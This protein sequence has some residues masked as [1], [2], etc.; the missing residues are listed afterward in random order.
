VRC[1][2]AMP[3]PVPKMVSVAVWR[4]LCRKTDVASAAHHLGDG[5]QVSA[6]A[7]VVRDAQLSVFHGAAHWIGHGLLD[8]PGEG[9]ALHPVMA[10]CVL[11]I[12]DPA[13]AK[14]RRIDAGAAAALYPW[15]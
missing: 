1:L 9:H 13:N 2:R 4:A 6:D 11:R 12:I 14:A 10:P 8:G 3:M 7:L 15:P 5:A